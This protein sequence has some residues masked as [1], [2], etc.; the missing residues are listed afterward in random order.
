LR[1]AGCLAGGARERLHLFDGFDGF[2]QIREYLGD[3]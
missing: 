1:A 3:V 2:D